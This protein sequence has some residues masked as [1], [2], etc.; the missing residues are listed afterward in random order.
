MFKNRKNNQLFGANRETHPHILKIKQIHF[1]FYRQT[2][3][4]GENIV[5]DMAFP[6]SRMI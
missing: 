6:P 1:L 5:S 3:R 4:G 2:E